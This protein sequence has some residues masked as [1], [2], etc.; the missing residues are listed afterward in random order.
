MTLFQAG[1]V[2]VYTPEVGMNLHMLRSDIK[3]LQKRYELDEKGKAEGRLV[4]K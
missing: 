2:I 1:A 3:F 4:L